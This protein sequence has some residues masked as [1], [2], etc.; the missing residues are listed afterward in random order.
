ME[1]EEEEGRGIEIE[2]KEHVTRHEQ[3][4]SSTADFTADIRCISLPEGGTKVDTI[5]IS[6]AFLHTP[7]LALSS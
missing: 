7:H 5:S 6:I 1:R 3:Q 2:R 4:A